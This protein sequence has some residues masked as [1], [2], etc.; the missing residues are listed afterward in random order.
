MPHLEY[1]V[2]PL[3]IT[4][5]VSSGKISPEDAHHEY[6][7]TYT[8]CKSHIEGLKYTE[9]ELSE[10][11]MDIKEKKIIDDFMKSLPP[12]YIHLRSFKIG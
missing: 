8:N 12:P 3:W 4:A 1:K 5:Y 2:N 11:M 10:M 7:K 6:L 9:A